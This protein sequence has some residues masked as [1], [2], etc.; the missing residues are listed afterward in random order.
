M[1]TTKSLAVRARLRAIRT[2]CRQLRSE[3]LHEIGLLDGNTYPIRKAEAFIQSVS[4]EASPQYTE[5]IQ[6]L[7]LTRLLEEIRLLRQTLLL[8]VK[9]F[10]IGEHTLI[11]PRT[12]LAFL[13]LPAKGVRKKH[14]QG[15]NFQLSRSDAILT[16]KVRRGRT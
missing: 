6:R 1:L 16:S 5:V 8:K 2:I 9:N 10:Q 7:L 11:L 15:V 14:Q 12:K 4:S 3:N 13:R